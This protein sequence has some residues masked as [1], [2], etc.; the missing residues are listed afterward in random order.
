MPPFRR[1]EYA[2]TLL[3]ILVTLLVIGVLAGMIVPAI[4]GGRDKAQVR[5]AS[6]ALWQAARFT[7][8][9]A[10]LRGMDHRLVLLMDGTEGGPGFR[11]EVV[12]DDAE[13]EDGYARL[14]TGAFK[15]QTFARG[16][17]FGTVRVLGETPS[18][19]GRVAI[20]FRAAG[21]ADAAAVV[22]TSWSPDAL[23]A[24]SLLV[25][26][27]SGRVQRVDRW[28]DTPPNDREDLDV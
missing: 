22:L 13:N 12:D 10:V 6:Q 9:R 3:E 11:I 23:V 19:E 15:P 18:V 16:V 27:N 28:V 21:D 17:T 5:D 25:S 1:A 14:T 26:P 20:D 8:Q 7:Q 2:F 4:G 24:Y